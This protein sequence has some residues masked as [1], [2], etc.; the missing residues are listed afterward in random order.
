MSINDRIQSNKQNQ[1]ESSIFEGFGG[2]VNHGKWSFFTA[3]AWVDLKK[4][5]GTTPLAPVLQNT[6]NW[7]EI[8]S[9]LFLFYSPNLPWL[10][11]ALFMY[12]FTP[13]NLSNEFTMKKWFFNRL[14]I[15]LI[16]TFGY[17]G[18][19]H[20]SLYFLNWYFKCRRIRIYWLSSS[21]I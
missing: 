16:M 4:Q 8:C 11:I 5:P 6:P 7:K 18:F 17:F 15:N 10:V 20:F 19:W 9:G 21:C 1:N 2:F 3:P 12:Y 13:Y 14:P